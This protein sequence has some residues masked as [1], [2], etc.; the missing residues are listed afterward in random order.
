M[1]KKIWKIIVGSG[2]IITI[3]TF[4]VYA[5]LNW[6]QVLPTLIFIGNIIK[7]IIIFMVQPY[8][9]GIYSAILIMSLIYYLYTR[10]DK[11]NEPIL[12]AIEY[13]DDA[14][15]YTVDVQNNNLTHFIQKRCK[16]CGCLLLNNDMYCPKCN[17]D[18]SILPTPPNT[19]TSNNERLGKHEM[20]L[21]IE[22]EYNK[23]LEGKESKI[24]PKYR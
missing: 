11:L 21:I 19:F 22:S 3:L 20:W 17:K 10:K 14:I 12:V 9:L 5:I 24:K 4:I 2:G 8:F 23:F 18:Y 15:K 7:T 16:T 13:E 6:N 1:M